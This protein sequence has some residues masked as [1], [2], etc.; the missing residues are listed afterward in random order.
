M[1]S[2]RCVNADPAALFAAFEALGSRRTRAVYVIFI[3]E[4]L[5][6]AGD[7][8]DPYHLLTNMILSG[9]FDGL[10]EELGIA[11]PLRA[12]RVSLLTLQ[13]LSR[14]AQRLGWRPRACGH[15][16]NEA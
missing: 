5:R 3:S 10:F 2:G 15:L 4:T 11:A 14:S 7:V 9:E 16:R 13:T 8:N 1:R 6:K 12:K